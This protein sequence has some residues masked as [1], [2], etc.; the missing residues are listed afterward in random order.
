MYEFFEDHA[1]VE[2]SVEEARRRCAAGDPAEALVLG[3]DLH[4][5]SGGEPVLEEFARDLLVAA[6]GALDRPALAETAAAHHRHRD[7]P[8]VDVL[9]PSG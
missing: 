6:Y 3:R 5:A 9:L 4:W 7:L 8:R 2:R 1:A